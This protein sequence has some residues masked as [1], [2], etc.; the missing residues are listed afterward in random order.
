MMREKS[1]GKEVVFTLLTCGIYGLFWFMDMTEDV[2]ILANDHKITGGMA[3]LFTVITCGI[4]ALYWYYQMGQLLQK[5]K[6]DRG[7]LVNQN[8]SILYLVL[9]L[10]G[11]GIIS[12]C[13]IQSEIN[14]LV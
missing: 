10:F 4:Y 7:M 5:A 1:I 8:N 3:L 6:Y 12:E 2:G 14:E 9:G 13:L 11:L